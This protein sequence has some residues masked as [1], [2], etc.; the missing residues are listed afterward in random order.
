MKKKEDNAKKEMDKRG[1]LEKKRQL[2]SNKYMKRH[3]TQYLPRKC[4]LKP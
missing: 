4:S 3:S 2:H 1:Q